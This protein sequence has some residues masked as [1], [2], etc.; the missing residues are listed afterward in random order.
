M[1]YEER[2]MSLDCGMDTYEQFSGWCQWL[3]LVVVTWETEN[4][5]LMMK[6]KVYSHNEIIILVYPLT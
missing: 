6:H 3:V 1:K 4:D 2:K 5:L